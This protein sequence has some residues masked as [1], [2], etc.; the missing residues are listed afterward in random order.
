MSVCVLSPCLPYRGGQESRCNPPPRE[1]ARRQVHRGVI[2]VWEHASY[3]MW[4][5]GRSGMEW[6]LCHLAAEFK[7]CDL[8][9]IEAKRWHLNLR[10]NKT[11]INLVYKFFWLFTIKVQLA[12]GKEQFSISKYF[13]IWFTWWLGTEGKAVAYWCDQKPWMTR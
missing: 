5:G 13:M 8:K 9:S 6:D 10:N 7:L 3:Q 2:A 12:A 4:W 1:A 11:K